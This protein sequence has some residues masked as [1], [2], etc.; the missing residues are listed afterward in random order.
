[1]P[2]TG[3]LMPAKQLSLPVWPE[4]VALSR[5]LLRPRV[6]ASSF[7]MPQLPAGRRPLHLFNGSSKS[8]DVQV[9]VST[10]AATHRRNQLDQVGFLLLRVVV[11]PA[12]TLSA[13]HS[14]FD[15]PLKK[16][17]W[18]KTQFEVLDIQAL[19]DEQHGVQANHVAQL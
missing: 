2:W 4:G 19:G 11:K 1:M 12:A 5:W 15:V 18:S 13:V 10:C 16:R 14:R 6:A 7:A 17:R 9:V 3:A 8:Q